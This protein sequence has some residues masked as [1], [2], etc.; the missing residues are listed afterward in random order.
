ML[1]G[2]SPGAAQAFTCKRAGHRAG[3]ARAA[4]RPVCAAGQRWVCSRDEL[5]QTP[6][7]LCGI[8]STFSADGKMLLIRKEDGDSGNWSLIWVSRR[9]GSSVFSAPGCVLLWKES[10]AQT[11]FCFVLP[12]LEDQHVLLVCNFS[13][14]SAD[15]LVGGGAC[16]VY[17]C[18]KFLCSKNWEIP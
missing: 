13:V 9:G 16:C 3:P 17:S 18:I 1:L 12:G 14:C 2:L 15:R 7:S 8:L 10:R 5:K 6:V 11:V 4:V